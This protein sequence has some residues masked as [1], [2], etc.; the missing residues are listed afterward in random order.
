MQQDITEHL[1]NKP[2]TVHTYI[3]STVDDELTASE[4][5]GLQVYVEVRW[6]TGVVLNI[7]ELVT[8][9]LMI[10]QC[11]ILQA[12]FKHKRIRGKFQTLCHSFYLIRLN[13]A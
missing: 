3:V 8:V 5:A 12:A 2:Y 13:I 6:R 7:R 1:G 11:K 9:Q 10:K 4:L